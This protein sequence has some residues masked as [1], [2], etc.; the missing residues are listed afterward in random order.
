LTG[1][2]LI[3]LSLISAT[4][5]TSSTVLIRGQH[6]IYDTITVIILTVTNLCLRI[7]RYTSLYDCAPLARCTRSRGAAAL[8][9][10]RVQ[11]FADKVL[12]G[13]PVTVII[14][15]ITEKAW[16]LTL[17]AHHAPLITHRFGHAG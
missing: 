11:L 13:D 10:G 6:V 14:T 7:K 5:S 17:I 1:V 8:S 12:I 16:V 9:T 4:S 3:L 15:T 2:E